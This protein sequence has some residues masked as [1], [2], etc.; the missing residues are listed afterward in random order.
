MYNNL[1]V[2]ISIK[3]QEGCFNLFFYVASV[4]IPNEINS[5]ISKYSVYSPEIN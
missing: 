5:K 3:K 2:L 4:Q 1:K